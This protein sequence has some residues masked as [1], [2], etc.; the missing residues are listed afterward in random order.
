M[1]F[2][3]PVGGG[4]NSSLR[5]NGPQLRK[6]KN[7]ADELRT[8]VKELRVQ[9][10]GLASENARLVLLVAK[11]EG[12]VASFGAGVNILRPSKK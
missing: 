7:R 8:E 10:R 9:N 12:V 6:H 5:L 3:T 1:R 2:E 4:R 11:L